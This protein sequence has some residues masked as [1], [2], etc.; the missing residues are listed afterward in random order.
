MVAVLPQLSIKRL[1]SS[2]IVAENVPNKSLCQN[3]VPK[4]CHS[5]LRFPD[6]NAWQLLRK[7]GEA[8]RLMGRQYK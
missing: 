2:V 4:M 6:Q 3:L 7:Q 8:W 5:T 1:N